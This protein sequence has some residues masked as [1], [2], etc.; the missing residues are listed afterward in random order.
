MSN[1]DPNFRKLVIKNFRNLAPFC[2]G[3]E[4]DSNKDKEFLTINRSLEREELGGIV[5][6]IGV[7]NSGK[8]NVLDAL[9]SFGYQEYD[10]D[11]Y[12]D[13]LYS[14]R[15]E[16]NVS[17]NVANGK[18]GNVFETSKDKFTFD[19]L[20]GSFKDV[21]FRIL[22]EEESFELYK[23][24]VGRQ[25]ESK[26]NENQ[27]I[28]EAYGQVF[29]SNEP[30]KLIQFI[31]TERDVLMEG[32]MKFRDYYDK[33]T[34]TRYDPW[35]T[36]RTSN[37]IVR[38]ISDGTLMECSENKLAS[39]ILCKLEVSTANGAV[40]SEE[41]IN[42]KNLE[43]EKRYGY[44]LSNEIVYYE[45]ERTDQSE[46]SCK[47]SEPNWLILA[48][49]DYL[50]YSESAIKNS[51]ANPML[52]SKLEKKINESL[53]MVSD[54]FNDL[55]NI[56]EK[57]YSFE[58]R[59]EK[60]NIEVMLTYGDGIP[61]NIDRQSE[62]FGWLFDFYFNLIMNQEFDPGCIVLIDEF[63]DS[64]GFSTVKELVRKLR[65]FAQSKGITFV[66]ATQNPMAVDILHLDE[67]RL[68]VPRE[69]GSAHI[70]NNFDQFGEA[71]SHD[72][73]DPVI[74]GLMV[75]RNFMRSENRRT[76]FVEGATDYFYFNAFSE[77]LR[78]RG[79]EVDVDFIPMNG[80][81]NREDSP[82]KILSQIKAIERYPTIF[83][84]SD[85]AGERFVSVAGKSGI[86]PSSISEIFGDGKREIEDLFSKKD[87]ERFHVA[88]KS[89]DRAACF[90]HRLGSI[91]DEIDEET[92]KNFEA[93][94]DYIMAQ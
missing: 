21:L 52:R 23:G 15:I 24:Y 55:L 20:Q 13:F 82:T 2:T 93:V 40:E 71:G 74:N 17:M 90:S 33:N 86:K 30:S 78:Q 45:R 89:F 28:T 9:V 61:L 27:W 31:L 58:I 76:V 75:S 65:R 29:Q 94:I 26:F 68:I 70:V 84:D 44:L 72:I 49:L 1:E 38:V 88:D 64:L 25:H 85:K 51:Y 18:Y 39:D 73:M 47:P 34:V 11:D 63:G 10:E 4:K 6:L 36:G 32:G 16:P 7:N 42:D 67:V 77:A 57:R 50:G 81:G 80:L 22:I 87:A 41:P 35:G 62:G 19:W 91:Y 3:T 59:L 43:F 5:T 66:L 37:E 69:D 12:T 53:S 46:L 8:T 83:V 54:E 48:L 14:D 92:K 56:D 79:K 60:D